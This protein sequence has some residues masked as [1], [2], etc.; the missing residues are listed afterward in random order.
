MKSKV[1]ILP[2]VFL[3][4]AG[5]ASMAPPADSWLPASH[6]LL[7]GVDRD[8]W[9]VEQ[10]RQV[11]ARPALDPAHKAA[12][13]QP[14]KAKRAVKRARP[15]P[16]PAALEPGKVPTGA[17]QRTKRSAQKRQALKP[18]TPTPPKAPAAA[19]TPP[20]LASNDSASPTPGE[21]PA[22]EAASEA[23]DD[24]AAAR[25]LLLSIGQPDDLVHR[26]RQLI[27]QRI[28]P[29][30]FAERVVGSPAMAALA[31]HGGG[32]NPVKALY[33]KLRRLKKTFEVGAPKRGDLV[34]FH[35]TRDLN[36]DNRNNDWYATVGVVTGVEPDGVVT[37]IA[38]ATRKVAELR[39]NLAHPRTR[40]D[41]HRQRT[42]NSFIRP[43]RLNDPATTRYLAGEL[44]AC[45]AE[46]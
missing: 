34:F 17:P 15:K 10:I 12:R 5:C 30:E 46:M 23:T 11:D 3:L 44:F 37:F 13:K 39:V 38:P 24:A 2:I 8:P 22:E 18:A 35:N 31:Y 6:N 19:A 21:E 7:S 9:I 28:E 36:G 41:E 29:R 42:L 14:A 40:R 25:K 1:K 16:K 43:K 45:F 32:R 4:A 20:A 26:S 27:G 33:L